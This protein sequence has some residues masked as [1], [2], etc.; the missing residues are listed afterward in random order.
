MIFFLISLM[1]I[2]NPK[3]ENIRSMYNKLFYKNNLSPFIPFLNFYLIIYV[4][5]IYTYYHTNRG[6]SSKLKT[7]EY[8]GKCVC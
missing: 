5:N 8:M 2:N 4:P 6:P 1:V 3:I 7:I